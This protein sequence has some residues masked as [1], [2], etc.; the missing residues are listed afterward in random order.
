MPISQKYAARHQSR[1][2]RY[3]NSGMRKAPQL[4]RSAI[5]APGGCASA[6]AD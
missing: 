1:W 3:Q 2:I 5:E 6:E 4:N